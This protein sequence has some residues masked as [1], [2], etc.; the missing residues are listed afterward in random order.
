MVQDGTGD[1]D[2][3]SDVLVSEGDD[4]HFVYSREKDLS[5]SIVGV[6][7]LVEE[8]GCG[9]KS[10][11]KFGVLGASGVGWDDGYR[12]GVDGHYESGGI[13]GVVNGVWHSQLGKAEGATTKAGLDRGGF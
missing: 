1:G 13:Q 8:C 4:E 7:I 11:V 12:S 10:I 2:A 3:V 5:E 6:I 9:V